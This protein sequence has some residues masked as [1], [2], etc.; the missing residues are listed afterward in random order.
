MKKKTYMVMHKI[1]IIICVLHTDNNACESQY[2][3][4]SRVLA[5]SHISQPL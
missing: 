4:Y 3:V 5:A 1:L 2:T